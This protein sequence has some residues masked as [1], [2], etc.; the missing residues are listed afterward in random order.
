MTEGGGMARKV[1]LIDSGDLG[2][3]SEGKRFLCVVVADGD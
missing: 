2:G 3:D 1:G